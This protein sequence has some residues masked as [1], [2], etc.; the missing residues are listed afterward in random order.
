MRGRVLVFVQQRSLA[1]SVR[2]EDFAL[3]CF[4]SE[5]FCR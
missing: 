1:G 3:N 5:R 4:S 2:D